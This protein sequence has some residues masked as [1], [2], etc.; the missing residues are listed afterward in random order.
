MNHF[1]PFQ[2]NPFT[3]QINHLRHRIESETKQIYNSVLINFYPDG[4]ASLAAHS[5][6]DPWLGEEFDVPS[7]SLGVT[8][9]I[10]FRPKKRTYAY[11]T[12]GRVKRLTNWA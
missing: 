8:R 1:N 10:V 2:A 9:T 7:V 4:N 12:A 6:N 11:R 3:S 5:D